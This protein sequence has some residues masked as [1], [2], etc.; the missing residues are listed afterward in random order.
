MGQRYAL[1]TISSLTDMFDTGLV[2]VY[3][4]ARVQ[5]VLRFLDG[6]LEFEPTPGRGELDAVRLDTALKQPVPDG[7]DRLATWSKRRCDFTSGPVL[8]VVGRA[9]MR[10]IVE[11]FLKVLEVGL[12][13]RETKGEDS[14]C[15]VLAGYLP[16]RRDVRAPLM[17]SPTGE[18]RIC[19][20]S[21]SERQENEWK[22][23]R[24]HASW[25][26]RNKRAY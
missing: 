17:E 4:V 9:G 21:K 5:E 7:V 18:N 10:H 13:E 3:I 22:E 1:K 6:G 26:G 11:V 2:S 19:T 20:S 14:R 23:K 12:R 25:E 15:V 24:A 8:A 16:S